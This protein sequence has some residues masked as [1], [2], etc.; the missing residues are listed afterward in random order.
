MDENDDE[1][2]DDEDNDGDD[3]KRSGNNKGR[4]RKGELTESLF[5]VCGLCRTEPCTSKTES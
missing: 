2:D 3:E 5:A 1:N 4:E